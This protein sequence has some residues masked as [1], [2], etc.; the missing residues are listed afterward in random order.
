MTAVEKKEASNA[1]CIASVT[2]R[3]DG[4]LE[5]R[6]EMCETKQAERD[7]SAKAECRCDE[8]GSSRRDGYGVGCS[9]GLTP[10][11][12][13][14]RPARRHQ[15]IVLYGNRE[16][17]DYGLHNAGE[18]PMV[19]GAPVDSFDFGCALAQIRNGRNVARVGWN[20]KG[21]HVALVFACEGEPQHEM[22]THPTRYGQ[23]ARRREYLSMRTA[24]GSYVP[25]VASQSDLLADDWI[26]V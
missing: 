9:E 19:D 14:S 7:E 8:V 24:D 20:G 12:A 15:V 22:S 21:M 5:K 4:R 17:S 16:K 10:V 26:V 2:A 6:N 13:G 18:G 1:D 11:G 3:R 23:H 25:W